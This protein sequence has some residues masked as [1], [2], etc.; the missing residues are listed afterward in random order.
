MAMTYDSLIALIPFY[1]D[2]NDTATLDHIPDFVFFAQQRMSRDL[3][4]NLGLVVY[5]EDTFVAQESLQEKPDNWRRNITISYTKD[6]IEYPLELRSYEYCK[7]YWPN[8]SSYGDPEFY[9]DY[10]EDEF[11]VVPTPIAAYDYTLGSSQIPVTLSDDNQT[12]F[13]TEITPDALLSACMSEAMKYVKNDERIAFWEA[14]YEKRI[15]SIQ[16]QNSMRVVDRNSN[17]NA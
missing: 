8:S 12:N 17:R 14:D 1:L 7:A 15:S 2:K 3:D 11:L 6:D 16:N 5:T 4:P 9:A 10:S 13:F